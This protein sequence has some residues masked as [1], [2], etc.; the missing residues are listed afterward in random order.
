[1]SLNLFDCLFTQMLT[2]N[3]M[4][5]CVVKLLKSNDEEA[6]ECLC[7]LL[8]TIGKDLDHAKAK[9]CSYITCCIL[10]GMPGGGT[11]FQ[12]I[13]H[14]FSKFFFVTPKSYCFTVLVWKCD[15]ICLISIQIEA[16]ADSSLFCCLE[17]SV[18]VLLHSTSGQTRSNLCVE[19]RERKQNNQV[20]QHLLCTCYITIPGAKTFWDLWE[21]GP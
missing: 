19:G 8:V 21:T 17:L 12:T 18:A 20:N 5:D 3:I 7:K 16:L 14:F 1:M 15:T 6:F 2:E 11:L 9:V 13:R 10:P 4:H